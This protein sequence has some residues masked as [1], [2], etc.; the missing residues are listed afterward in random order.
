MDLFNCW[1]FIC[2]PRSHEDTKVHEELLRYYLRVS[3][4]L[5]AIVVK[6]ETKNL[7]TAQVSSHNHT[8]LLFKKRYFFCVI[9]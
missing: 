2:W 8:I 7:P 3:S 5:R 9:R 6:R 4:S 1:T